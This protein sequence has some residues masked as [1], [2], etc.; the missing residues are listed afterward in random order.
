ME[1]RRRLRIVLLIV[2]TILGL[3]ALLSKKKP[4]PSCDDPR[5][6]A[7]LAVLYDNQR[8]L[9]A[10]DISN[11]RLL[12]DGFKGRYCIATVDWQKGSRTD[13]SYEFLL[14]GKHNEYMSMWIDYNGGMRGPN[15]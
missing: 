10:V 4:Y 3:L 12:S 14:G 6:K 13:V 5:A 1:P 2:F 9:H 11:L 8:L 15:F 7:T